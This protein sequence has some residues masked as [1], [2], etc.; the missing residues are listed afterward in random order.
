MHTGAYRCMPGTRIRHGRK[1]NDDGNSSCALSAAAL[2][3]DQQAIDAT[4][5]KNVYMYIYIVI[6]RH[7]W[8]PTMW[9][10]SLNSWQVPSL[11]FETLADVHLGT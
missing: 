10:F 6:G 2:S 3:R 8:A 11:G 5:K 4:K 7:L 1:T 9:L